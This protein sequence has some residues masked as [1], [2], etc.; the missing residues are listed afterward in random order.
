MGSLLKCLGHLFYQNTC[1][2]YVVSFFPVDGTDFNATAPRFFFEEGALSE[3][4]I[5]VTINDDNDLEG[6]HTFTV[7]LGETIDPPLEGTPSRTSTTI[8]IQDREGTMQN[9]L[10]Q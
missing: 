10:C 3:A 7:G 2:Y 1:I 9:C 4:C 8:T 6:D 5:D